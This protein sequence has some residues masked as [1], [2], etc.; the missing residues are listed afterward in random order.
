MRV[1]YFVIQ[2]IDSQL[3]SANDADYISESIENL[4]IKDPHVPVPGTPFSAIIKSMWPEEIVAGLE[5]DS[6]D[7]NEQP[8][9]R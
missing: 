7:P 2:K 9:Y 5:A 4:T 6:V 3:E 8:E 1:I